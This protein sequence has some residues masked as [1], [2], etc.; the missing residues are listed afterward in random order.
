[1]LAQQHGIF[2]GKQVGRIEIARVDWAGHRQ[3]GP[4]VER[5]HEF[6]RELSDF[7]LVALSFCQRG[8]ELQKNDLGF[9]GLISLQILFAVASE[10]PGFG[11]REHLKVESAR[12]ASS[13]PAG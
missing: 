3:L 8:T 9:G 13:S 1:M 5:G 4:G 6:G 7:V 2:G 11:R 10:L 12:C